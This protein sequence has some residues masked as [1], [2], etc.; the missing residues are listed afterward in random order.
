MTEQNQQHG[1]LTKLGGVYGTDKLLHGYLELY[2]QHLPKDVRC[3]LEIGIAKGASAL[4]WQAYYPECDL[5]YI[6]LF[7]HPDH[8]SV[9]WCREHFIVPHVCDQSNLECLSQIKDQFEVIIDDGSHNSD[10]QLISF[11]HLFVNNLKPGGLYI[12]EDLH[13]CTDPFYWNGDQRIKDAGDTMLGLAA[14]YQREQKIKNPFFSEGES[15]VFENTIKYLRLEA[16]SKI[17]F[18]WK[19]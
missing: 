14:I 4:M 17:V 13:C 15:E 9:H 19:H 6:D 10:H 12:V 1:R 2:E 8:V 7:G 16:E 18:I 11:H 5:H 3:L